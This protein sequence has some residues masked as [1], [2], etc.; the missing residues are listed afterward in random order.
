MGNT[1]KRQRLLLIPVALFLLGL[2]PSLAQA[3]T[4][5]FVDLRENAPKDEIRGPG[6][7]YPSTIAVSGLAGTVTKV[8]VTTI[9]LALGRPSDLDLLLVGPNGA[10]VML[11]SDACGET[12]TQN[13]YLTFDDAA[14]TFL[15]M[16]GPCAKN[17]NASF[18]PSN[19]FLGFGGFEEDDLS[20]TGGPPPP[21]T[22]SLS[23][24]NGS[25]PSGEWKLFALDD[26]EGVVG[27]TMHGWVLRLEVEPPPTP[28]PPAPLIVQVPAPSQT[29][30][31]TGQR[32]KALAKC[33]S[34]PTKKARRKCKSKA[35]GLPL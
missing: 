17:L 11:M 29:T 1:R 13:L 21:Y 22:N 2:L 27:W 28:P 4:H 26:E 33:K 34:K 7:I 10:Q 24:F 14:A 25:A 23:A 18:K 6:L 9:E 30:G 3:Q 15:S 35:K 8:T 20:P 5:T 19:Y 31:P 32:A 12:P 16:N